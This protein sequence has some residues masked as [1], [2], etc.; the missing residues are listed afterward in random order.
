MACSY[1]PP[2][3]AGPRRPRSGA[4]RAGIG[5]LETLLALFVG[6]LVLAGVTLLYGS[7]EGQ[8][9]A[10]ATYDEVASIIVASKR[11]A[12]SRSTY[13]GVTL[14]SL[15]NTGDIPRK[16]INGSSLYVPGGGYVSVTPFDL[17]GG[18]STYKYMDIRLGNLTRA[19]CRGILSMD[20]SG[21]AYSMTATGYL[22]ESWAHPFPAE[23]LNK[24]CL[25]NASN[26]IDIRLQ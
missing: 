26:Y 13:R 10:H 6:G 2:A 22:Y 19:Q 7:G 16:Y 12:A 9:Q 1:C 20:F 17:S 23:Q 14:V 4:P 21:M 24:A 11:V 3:M 25:D 15:I 5:L 8:R 18:S